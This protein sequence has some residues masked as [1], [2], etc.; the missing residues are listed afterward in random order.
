MVATLV[1]LE[2]LGDGST[3]PERVRIRHAALE[4]KRDLDR[5]AGCMLLHQRVYW[6][7][8]LDFVDDHGRFPNRVE[9]IVEHERFVG[10]FDLMAAAGGFD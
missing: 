7:M 6:Q 5:S 10:V 9:R 8:I 1:Q 2:G 4:L 3:I